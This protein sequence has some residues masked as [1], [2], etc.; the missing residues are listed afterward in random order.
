MS[1]NAAP[2]ADFADPAVGRV[3]IRNHAHELLRRHGLPPLAGADVDPELRDAGLATSLMEAFRR[4]GDPEVF[5]CLARWAAPQLL[6][7][8]RSRLRG[9]GQALD[10]QEILQDALVNVYRYPDRFLASRPGAFAA[11]ST[12]II[13]NVIRRQLRRQRSGPAVALQAPEL[14]QER[15]DAAALEPPAVVAG[16]EQSVATARAFAVLLCGYD[17]AFR[18]LRQREQF[19]LQLVEVRGLRYAQ[20]AAMLGIRAEAVKMIVFRARRRLFERLAGLLGRP[21]PA[22]SPP[23]AEPLLASA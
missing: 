19:A 10:A 20:I 15:A 16:R 23:S 12:T 22:A 1:C 21:G 5:D 8:I 2:N 13:D 7:R 11:W 9:L 14:L 17:A 4:S 6:A 18:A 3:R